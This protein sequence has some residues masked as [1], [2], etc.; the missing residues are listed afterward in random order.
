VDDVILT[1][2]NYWQALP[3]FGSICGI[4]D[5][6]KR[7]MCLLCLHCRCL[8]VLVYYQVW[9]VKEKVGRHQRRWDKQGHGVQC[10][11]P[12]VLY[13]VGFATEKAS[14]L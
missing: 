12:S 10:F 7:T 5:V 14:G 3:V 1:T 4:L 11:I 13:S 9:V 6:L 8:D 2:K